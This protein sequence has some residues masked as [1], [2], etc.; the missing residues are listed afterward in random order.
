M[1]LKKEIKKLQDKEKAKILQRFFKTGKQ[2][3]GE[4][5]LFLGVTVPKI[6]NLVKIYWKPTLFQ[7]I[8]ELILSK[9][10]EERLLGLLILVKKYENSEEKVKKEIVEFY[11]KNSKQINNWDLVDLTAYNILGDYLL[12]KNKEVLYKLSKSENLWEKRISIISTLAF[13]KK[14]K[15]QDTIKISEI[16]LEDKHDLIHKAV[17]WMLREMGKKDIE[18]LEKFLDKNY[19]K[20]SRT[21]L[22]Y[23]IERMSE[24]RRRYYLNKQ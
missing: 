9:Y 4:E 8:Q 22:R 19:K 14:N 13:I 16:L 6:R 3:Y 1:R 23:S 11:L 24:Q 20:M 21:T 2:E 7:E 18:E 5:D 10:H 15:F 17:G 12:D